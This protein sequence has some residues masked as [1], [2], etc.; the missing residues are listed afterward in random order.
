LGLVLRWIDKTTFYS[1]DDTS[2]MIFCDLGRYELREGLI[3]LI[4]TLSIALCI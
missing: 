3:G 2:R 1:H 4:A